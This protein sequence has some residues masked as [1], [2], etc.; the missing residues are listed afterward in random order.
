MMMPRWFSGWKYSAAGLP[1]RPSHDSVISEAPPTAIPFT[2][3]ITGIRV[4]RIARVM[5]WKVATASRT[6]A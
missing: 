1:M 5:S 3:A 4:S 6:S 2:A